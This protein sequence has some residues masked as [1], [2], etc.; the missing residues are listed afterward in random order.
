MENEKRM[1][2]L[3]VKT[4]ENIGKNVRFTRRSLL[5]I[6]YASMQENTGVSR[7]VLCRLE[8]L[9]NTSTNENFRGSPG[10]DTLIK[11]C[12]G[13]GVTPAELFE[14]EFS[15]DPDIQKRIL[16]HCKTFANQDK[17]TVVLK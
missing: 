17:N 16:E 8:D 7:D 3:S 10:F 14:K 6:T 9:S 13:V 2:E 15:S 11:F 4:L 1:S 5:N 12:D